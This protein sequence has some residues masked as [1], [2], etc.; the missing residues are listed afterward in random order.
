M[1]ITVR[2]T[3]RYLGEERYGML[4]TISSFTLLFGFSDLGIGNG[5]LNALSDADG[6]NAKSLAAQRVANA[7]LMLIVLATGLG[8]VFAIIYPFID[9][10]NF[11][12]VKS[13]IAREEAGPALL[14]TVVFFLLNFPLGIGGK[15]QAAY[16]EAFAA[17]IWGTVSQLFSL[18]GV[19][20]GIS[21]R[22]GVPGLMFAMFAG[23]IAVSIVN[24][25]YVLAFQRSW[26]FP[27]VKNLSLRAARS[28][29]SFGVAFFVLSICGSMAFFADNIITA[30]V[31]NASSVTQYSIPM[32]LF[33]LPTTLLMMVLAPLWP[34][35]SEANARRD[36]RWIRQTLIRSVWMTLLISVPASLALSLTLRRILT[37]WVGPEIRPSP[38][39]ISGMAIWCVMGAVGNALAMFLNGMHIMRFQVYAAVAM[40]VANIFLSVVLAKAIGL[41]GVIWGTVISYAVF[42][43]APSILFIPRLLNQREETIHEVNATLETGAV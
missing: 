9:W 18:T 14:V 10:S 33:S 35:Y 21:N 11:F 1:F 41:P 43:L 5:L 32:R 30:K 2:L 27:T 13:A 7:C 16:Q 40:A 12:N 38:G 24:N 28:L 20:V 15:I 25:V 39:L 36:V 17:S 29:F 19:F 6:R 22:V 37:I 8:L 26:L 23:P 34:A 3:A 4:M 42:V 31:L